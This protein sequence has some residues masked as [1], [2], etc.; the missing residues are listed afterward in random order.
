MIRG[1]IYGNDEPT[2]ACYHTTALCLFLFPS[3]P[4]SRRLIEV[5]AAISSPR[6]LARTLFMVYFCRISVSAFAS[7]SG[8]MALEG[9]AYMLLGAIKE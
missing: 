9:V 8:A 2:L 7:E 6:D 3:P 5:A 4:F 1:L